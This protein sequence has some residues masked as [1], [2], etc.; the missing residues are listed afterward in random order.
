MLI[1]L[2][3]LITNPAGALTAIHKKYGDFVQTKFFN[4]RLLFTSNPEHYEE[5]FNQEA[6][7]LLNRDSL[8]EA[9]KPMFGDGLFNSKGAT[10]TNQRRLMQPLFTKQAI[11]EWHGIML[12]EAGKAAVRLKNDG[13]TKVNISEELKAIIQSILIQVMFGQTKS[14]NSEELL[15]SAIDTIVKGLFPHLLT[16]TLGKGIL[17]QLFFLQNRRMEKAI[18]QFVAYVDAKI[19]GIEPTGHDLISLMMKGR[20]R[21]GSHMSRALLR[22]EAVTLFLAGQD[23]T[24]N[25]LIWFFYLIGKHEAVHK[26]ITREIQG[27]KDD[28]LTPDTI[29]QLIY[30][31]AA[32]YETLRLY[33]QAIALSR[34]TAETIT[35]GGKTVPQGTSVIMSLYATNRDGRWWARPNEFHPEHFL[36]SGVT[37]RHKY[38]FLPFGGGVHNC[39]GRHFAELEMMVIIATVLREFTILVNE[40]IKPTVSITYKPERDVIVS[41]TPTTQTL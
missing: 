15:M 33:P 5:I 19:D 36:N 24:V 4:K 37:P 14:A 7:G 22:D 29:E 41:I 2:V 40:E 1:Y 9:K 23:T 17:K 16:E 28:K 3:R 38:T 35:V 26:R 25:T 20:D 8:Y 12:K 13:I 39:V 21:N 34:D 6:R 30:T 27:L 18:N 11:A 32:L 10:W 31:K